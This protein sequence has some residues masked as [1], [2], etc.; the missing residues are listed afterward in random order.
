MPDIRYTHAAASD[1]ESIGDALAVD[2][3]VQA[4]H[5]LAS[6]RLHCRQLAR[7]S[8]MGIACPQEGEGVR[9][10]MIG[11]Y[12]IFYRRSESGADVLRVLPYRVE[13]GG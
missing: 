12:V 3:P 13:A 10:L 7:V 4:G 6:V 11:R 1:L 9:S 8:G 2:D 5:F